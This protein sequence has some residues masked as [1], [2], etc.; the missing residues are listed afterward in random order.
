MEWIIP[1][2]IG[3]VILGVI[4]AIVIAGKT[5]ADKDD[6]VR[7]ARVALCTLIWPVALPVFLI[8]WIVVFFIWLWKKAD[9]GDLIG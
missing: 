5:Y 2:Y 7:S 6:E 3:G 1:V 9:W 4:L 8:V